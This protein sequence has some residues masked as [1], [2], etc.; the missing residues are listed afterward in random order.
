MEYGGGRE[1]RIKGKRVT[2]MNISLG[3]CLSSTPLLMLR[4]RAG[5]VY[6]FPLGV[7]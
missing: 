2:N 6:S 7:K 5:T 3:I 1:I 4:E